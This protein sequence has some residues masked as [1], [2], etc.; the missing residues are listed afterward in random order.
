MLYMYIF[1]SIHTYIA[2]LLLFFL[3]LCFLGICGDPEPAKREARSKALL[4]LAE[5]RSEGVFYFVVGHKQ[6]RKVPSK[7]VHIY[8]PRTHTHRYIYV[9]ICTWNINILGVCYFITCL[10]KRIWE[11][12]H[13]FFGGTD[14]HKICGFSQQNSQVVSANNL[15]FAKRG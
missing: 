14:S 12:N 10:L 15:F 11:F 5:L 13:H 1:V 2:E 9:Y 3:W 7:M 6:I 8:T 4:A